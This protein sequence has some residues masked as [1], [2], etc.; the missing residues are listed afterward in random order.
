MKRLNYIVVLCILGAL[1]LAM[2][3][4]IPA[5]AYPPEHT[6]FVWEEDD[7][8]QVCGVDLQVHLE[9]K[10]EYILWRDKNG[11][12]Y[13]DSYHYSTTIS[14]TNPSN[15]HTLTLHGI[16]QERW[17]WIIPWY[18]TIAEISGARWIGTVPGHG[19]VIGTVGR[20]VYYETCHWVGEEGG[21]QEC[22]NDYYHWSGMVFDDWD[23]VCD[24]L[25]NGN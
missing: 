6:K 3:A 16:I 13:G 17:T 9:E 25:G 18:E 19:V 2:V 1:I 4:T 7:V 10:Y 21:E 12:D 14:Y 24:Y 5:S 22:E 23:A 11:Q 15:G 20:Q 8:Q